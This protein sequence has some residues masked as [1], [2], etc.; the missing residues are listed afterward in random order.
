MNRFTLFVR[1][2]VL[3]SILGLSSGVAMA[4]DYKSYHPPNNFTLGAST[5]FGLIDTHGGLSVVG[6]IAAKVV[7]DGFV[8]DIV[9]PVFLELQVGPVFV[10][11]ATFWFYS[12]H[13]RWDFVK[14]EK[15]TF[16]AL[17]GFAGNGGDNKYGDRFAFHPRFG[18]GAFY[19]MD[20]LDLRFDFSRE[21][22]NFGVV[23][24]F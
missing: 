22:I 2:A 6:N 13:L 14:D 12:T 7:R 3:A 21:V 20:M 1:S 10:S 18:V 11:G 4:E 23:L 17:G 9:N 8:P 19:A 16:F 15:W 24:P 5:G